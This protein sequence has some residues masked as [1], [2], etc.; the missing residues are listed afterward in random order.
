MTATT[1]GLRR[2]WHTIGDTLAP[3]SPE[4]HGLV[5]L[6]I[7]MVIAASI[8]PVMRRTSP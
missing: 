3:L 4:I 5:S 2:V 1:K 6:G 8:W 7:A